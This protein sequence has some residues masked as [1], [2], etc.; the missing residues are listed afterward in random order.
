MKYIDKSK[1]NSLA[2][3]SA[4]HAWRDTYRYEFRPTEEKNFPQYFGFELSELCKK[5]P[6]ITGKYMFNII[7]SIE[8]S[9]LREALR[10]EQN[11]LCCY[12]CQK[13]DKDKD[14]SKKRKD[15]DGL[16]FEPIE[17]FDDKNKHPCKTF[18]YD[19]LLLACRGNKQP[20]KYHFTRNDS[21]ENIAQHF[22]ITVADLEKQNP[23]SS[24]WS[25][26]HMEA[27][28][29]KLPKHCDVAKEDKPIVINPSDP[30]EKDC[31]K[32][33]TYNKEGKI[34]AAKG[35]SKVEKAI[36]ILNLNMTALKEGRKTAWEAAEESYQEKNLN[37]FLENSDY[38]GYKKELQE[39]KDSASNA[40]FSPVYWY[41]YE[42]LSI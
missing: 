23:K 24:S 14:E 19:N 16:D 33:F 15:E 42:S 41:Y 27:I 3:A 6:E 38:E 1:P 20:E 13:L 8:K 31:W 5:K 35:D 32:K 30:L 26:N 34:Q 29:I 22:Q 17:H 18:N 12:C 37:G 10:N 2:A 9:N 39:L 21:K 25:F 11:G 4:L 7:P 36:E 40:P 28:N